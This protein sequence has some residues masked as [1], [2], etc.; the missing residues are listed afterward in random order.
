LRLLIALKCL[1]SKEK[2]AKLEGISSN[3]NSK[4]DDEEEVLTESMN[5]E[6][7]RSKEKNERAESSS[8]EKDK[9]V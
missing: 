3:E 8:R 1:D 2:D 6:Y 4:R 9:R 7:L 5:D